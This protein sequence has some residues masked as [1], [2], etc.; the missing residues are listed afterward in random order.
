MLTIQ[1]LFDCVGEHE[2]QSDNLNEVL[3]AVERYFTVLRVKLPHTSAGDSPEL[4]AA[5]AEII[6]PDLVQSV[7]RKTLGLID[8]IAMDNLTESK[9]SIV[10]Q[11]LLIILEACKIKND[12]D[13]N[14][15]STYIPLQEQIKELI[16]NKTSHRYD[17]FENYS[18]PKAEKIRILETARYAA[19][20]IEA[21]SYRNMAVRIGQKTEMLARVILSL[22]TPK[23]IKNFPFE[24]ETLQHSITELENSYTQLVK[25]LE[26]PITIMTDDKISEQVNSLEESSRKILNALCI[27][28]D[29]KLPALK[30]TIQERDFKNVLNHSKELIHHTT[31]LSTPDLNKAEFSVALKLFEDC[32]RSFII[33]ITVLA[34]HDNATKQRHADSLAKQYAQS[35]F[36]AYEGYRYFLSGDDLQQSGNTYVRT[37]P[38]AE[39]IHGRYILTGNDKTDTNLLSILTDARHNL[40]FDGA[41]L[42]DPSEENLRQMLMDK[43]DAKNADNIIKHYTQGMDFLANALLSAFA[44]PPVQN[45]PV[46]LM[47][48]NSVNQNIQLS[49]GNILTR[50]ASS[51]ELTFFVPGTTDEGSQWKFKADIKIIGRIIREGFIVEFVGTNSPCIANC[52]TREDAYKDIQMLVDEISK[53]EKQLT[54]QRSNI[55]I[56]FLN[57]FDSRNSIAEALQSVNSFK[58]GESS[59]DELVSQFNQL[60]ESFGKKLSASQNVV[61]SVAFKISSIAE[62]FKEKANK[63]LNENPRNNPS[64]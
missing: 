6:P 48:V 21:L 63:Y 15:Q 3:Q 58:S 1:E 59:L 28:I 30:A 56:K 14:D 40:H 22:E 2:H 24:N 38:A 61:Q 8:H 60:T 33:D 55:R 4:I 62:Q 26:N 7:Q 27:A 52:L 46:R 17:F 9:Y 44:A 12:S 19:N 39:S 11:Q 41:L 13:N 43:Y 34:G 5:L 10:Y 18:A 35:G 16:E 64:P 42:K 32:F 31:K 20:T 57:S 47:K 23:F 53:C 25:K 45:N 49:P 36:H 37:Q 29:F 51:S 50:D 54:A